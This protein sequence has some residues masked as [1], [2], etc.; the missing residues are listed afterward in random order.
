MALLCLIMTHCQEEGFLRQ[1][2]EE[3][4]S[5]MDCE[6]PDPIIP[7]SQPEEPLPPFTPKKNI[8]DFLSQQKKQCQGQGSPEVWM[9]VTFGYGKGGYSSWHGIIRGTGGYNGVTYY[10]IDLYYSLTEPGSPQ[11]QAKSPRMVGYA[12]VGKTNQFPPV[13]ASC[14]RKKRVELVNH[15]GKNRWWDFDV[16][17]WNI[18]TFY[19]IPPRRDSVASMSKTALFSFKPITFT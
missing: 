9:Y 14:K 17:S 7:P 19:F 6:Q 4:C 2:E 12:F 13:N 16:K 18:F 5:N 15:S 3:C 10:K 11:E 8:F 1:R